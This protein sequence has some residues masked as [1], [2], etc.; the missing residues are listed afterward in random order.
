VLI[1]AWKGSVLL[2]PDIVID[3]RLFEWFIAAED[4]LQ[5]R[6]YSLPLDPDVMKSS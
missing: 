2:R 6:K 3:H 1:S 4:F 5:A